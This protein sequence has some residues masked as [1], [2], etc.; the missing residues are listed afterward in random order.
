M[1]KSIFTLMTA[2]LLMAGPVVNVAHA[3][4][5]GT[6]TATAGTA[7]TKLEGTKFYLGTGTSA[8]FPIA[9]VTGSDYV[10]IGVGAAAGAGTAVFEVRNLKTVDETSVSFEL[11]TAGKQLGVKNNGTA[12]DGSTAAEDIFT[13]FV[14]TYADKKDAGTLNF[15]AIYV[16]KFGETAISNWGFYLATVEQDA[17]YLQKYNTNGITL[18]FDGKTVIGNAFEETLQVVP[19]VADAFGS[20]VGTANSFVLVKG[21]KD[22]VKA[23]KDAAGATT[24]GGATSPGTA[25]A[26]SQAAAL[27]AAKK[28]SFLSITDETYTI[29]G[30]QTASGEAA[31][32]KVLEKGKFVPVT[33]N[34]A[35]VL[36]TAVE[37]ADVL[38]NPAA[39]KLTMGD[40]V[41][42]GVQPDGKGDNVYVTTILADG[43]SKL[44]ANPAILGESTYLDASILL[45]KNAVNTVN[46]Y[47][48]SGDQSIEGNPE[49]QY[50]YHKYLVAG[51]TTS[52][53]QL[54][55]RAKS[56]INLAYPMTQWVVTGFDGKS[57]FTLT[58]REAKTAL[59]L[60]LKATDVEGEYAITGG[61]FNGT[62]TFGDNSADIAAGVTPLATIKGNQQL[63]GK[64]VRFNSVATTKTD[65][66]LEMTKAEREGGFHF[67][68]SGKVPGGIAELYGV[69][70]K[71]ATTAAATEGYAPKADKGD[72]AFTAEV[73]K[74]GDDEVAN[75][76]VNKV[77]AA[78]LDKDGNIV[79]TI[80]TL[81]VPSYKLYV[82]KTA[83]NKALYLKNDAKATV[84]TGATDGEFFFRKNYDGTYAMGVTTTTGEGDYD[85]D[86]TA[87]TNA[88]NVKNDGTAFEI[89]TATL[90]VPAISNVTIEFND[91]S[92]ATSLPAVPRHVSFDNALGSVNMQMNKNGFE[93]GILSTEGLI[94]WLDTVGKADLPKFYISRGVEGQAE[95][96]FMFNSKDSLGLFSEDD[97]QQSKNKNYLLEGTANTPKAIF[98]SASLIAK[99][100]LTTTID[101]EATKL[102]GGDL[103]AYQYTIQLNNED[104]DNE[105]VVKSVKD[106]WLYAL[107]GKLGFTNNRPEAMVFT[108]GDEEATAN[109][110]TPSVSEV[111]VIAAEGAIRIAGAQ[112][113]KVVI[114]NIL[115][116]VIANTVISSSDAT[117]AAPAGIVVVAV[118]GEEA[119]KAIVK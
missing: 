53:Y 4:G 58:N 41:I 44:T 76:I 20:S 21:T 42:G 59:V 23:F 119:V 57:T 66:F 85:T 56:E 86:I 68:F 48:T 71:A 3:A 29:N 60:S 84:E 93:E 116:Q 27:A 50:E 111:K 113:K 104:V 91:N 96:L 103:S 19:V 36:F 81:A 97:A 16:N 35:N 32:I 14:V 94:F 10:T 15:N 43:S 102:Y 87:T 46:I 38:N 49:K 73:V 69:L 98:R 18:S 83:A 107:N 79:M 100:T 17:E 55:A 22:D 106:G 115:G 114:S 2:A 95:R 90:Y 52:A 117:I 88:V 1:N 105:Y 47:F 65:G 28:V 63:I 109:E 82:G 33:A 99:D 12:F 64:V 37:Q 78:Y 45:K 5:A 75:Y 70:A 8:L 13:S 101:G 26:T 25:D 108:L 67:L 24:A 61:T 112:G 89:A 92:D 34:I 62:A 74:G 51:A 54:E 110:A 39:L 31:V 11:W 7:A 9:T 77:N 72:Y 40:F 6:I 80:D 30:A 118:E